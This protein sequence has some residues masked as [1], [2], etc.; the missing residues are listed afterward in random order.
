MVKDIADNI[1]RLQRQII[2][3]KKQ[4]E[5]EFIEMIERG[6]EIAK[7]ADI[8]RG[9]RDLIEKVTR[10]KLMLIITKFEARNK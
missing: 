8:T 4:N 7:I 3:L 10:D 5:T 6:K 9:H 1:Q 2:R